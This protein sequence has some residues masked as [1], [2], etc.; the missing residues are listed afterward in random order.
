M[1]RNLDKQVFTNVHG[2]TEIVIDVTFDADFESGD[3]QYVINQGA[4]YLDATAPLTRTDEGD[5]T[6]KLR[7]TWVGFA[8]MNATLNVTNVRT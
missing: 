2:L 3:P 7:D 5:V 1:N 8:G 4:G 6:F